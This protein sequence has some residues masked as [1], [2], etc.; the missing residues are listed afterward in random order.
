MSLYVQVP[1]RAFAVRVLLHPLGRLFFGLMFI[2]LLAGLGAFAWYWVQYAKLIEEKL[3]KGP[4]T[5]TSR[6]FAAPKTIAVG[7]A[8]KSEDVVSHLRRA[9]YSPSRSNRLGSWALRADGIEIYPGPESYFLR[10]PAVIQLNNQE[11]SSIISLRDNTQLTQ[12]QL[13]PEL[14]TNLFDSSRQK[15]RLVQ[16]ED[17]PRVLVDAVVSVEDKRYFQH[18]GFDPIRIVKAVIRDVQTGSKAEGAST[19]SQQLARG[20]FLT[21]EKTIKRKFIELVITLQMEMKLSKEQIFEYYANYVPLG[22]RGSFHIHGF[23]EASQAFLGKDMSELTAPEAALLAGIIRQPSALNP[24]RWPDRARN[25]RNLV[26]ALM[27]E[28]GK[29]TERECADAQATPLVLAKNAAESADAPYFVDLVNESLQEQFQNIDFTNSSLRVYT[30]LDPE[31]QHAA[32]E[33]VRSG[34][35]EVDAALQRRRATG[36]KLPEAQVSLVALDA[37]TGEVRALV[38]GRSYA[39]SQLNRSQARRQ[40][41]SIFKPFVYAAA[42]NTALYDAPVVFTPASVIQD[43]PTT[44]Y[45][46]GRSYEPGNFHG[47]YHGPVTLR[48]ALVHSMNIP[49]VKLAEA[50]GYRQVQKLAREAG[51]SSNLH[52]T[53]AMALGAYEA[54]PIEMAG[55]Y[56][57]YPSNGKAARPWWIRS[58]RDNS[59]QSI[60]E[61]KATQKQVLDPRVNYMMVNIMEDVMRSGT[62]AGARSRGFSLPA[63]GK[64]GTSRDGWF[65]GFT[66]RLVCVVWVGFDDN[67]ELPLEGARSALP[68]WTEFMKRAHG[69]RQYARVSSFEPAEGVTSVP[70]SLSEARPAGEAA[71][72]NTPSPAAPPSRSRS[73]VFVSGT[74]PVEEASGETRVS[75][76]DVPEPPKEGSSGEALPVQPRKTVK[77]AARR[78]SGT[79][80]EARPEAPPPPPAEEKAGFWNKVRGIFK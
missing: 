71:D 20:F 25:R 27:R 18:A 42:L 14:V 59:G 55:A 75:G 31:L 9:G 70:V 57:M 34:M 78:P 1:K 23:G 7:D 26:L 47:K 67:T 77:A 41:G 22:T 65:A 62:G 21:P 69:L 36:K 79:V 2:G 60:F 74:Q 80:I 30:T 38:G 10:E 76:W 58:V 17:I 8:L 29:L 66:S 54:T 45:F 16:Y 33:A 53:P 4:F 50:V 46:D 73:E 68:V 5:G 28:N 72:G 35:K 3:A 6:I 64:T 12:Y 44:F 43:E 48:Q 19:L 40:P 37:K 49:T 52:A 51:L 61:G 56:T 13:E 63:G 15:R 39:E 11:V 24:I 32:V